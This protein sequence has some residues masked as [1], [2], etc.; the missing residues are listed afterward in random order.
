MSPPGWRGLER[1]V[2]EA[3]L[4]Q[5]PSPGPRRDVALRALALL[6]RRRARD[7]GMAASRAEL[8]AALGASEDTLARALAELRDWGLLSWHQAGSAPAAYEVSAAAVR[9]WL[10]GELSPQDAVTNEGLPPQIA[11]A[12]EALSPQSAVTTRARGNGLLLPPTLDQLERLETKTAVAILTTDRIPGART[13]EPEVN[14]WVLRGARA[15]H[16]SYATRQA[17]R[18]GRLSFAYVEGVL[19]QLQA[20]AGHAGVPLADYDPAAEAES[21]PRIVDLDEY[22][23]GGGAA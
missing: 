1:R 8:A 2:A 9:A 19:R 15:A 12:N 4:G 20:R 13:L 7:E 21:D 22:R 3:V 14:A 6:V 10:D 17:V 11:A 16:W 5:V 18:Q 23:A